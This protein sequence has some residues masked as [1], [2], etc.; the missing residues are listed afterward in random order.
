S[1]SQ[2]E[3]WSR[4]EYNEAGVAEFMAEWKAA[5]E[6]TA[7]ENHS[8]VVLRLSKSWEPL[9]DS[10]LSQRIIIIGQPGSGK[11]NSVADIIEEIGPLGVPL[12]LLDTEG[13]YD[14][15][16]HS[17]YLPHGETLGAETIMPENAREFGRSIPAE[18]LQVIL[19][20]QSYKADDEAALVICELIAGINEWE[21]AQPAGGRV[22]CMVILDEAAVWLPQAVNESILSKPVLNQLQQT[23]FSTVVRRGRKR[24][25]GFLLATQRVAEIDKRALSATWVVLHRQTLP[26]DLKVYQQYGIEPEEARAL[27]PGQAYVLGPGD[28][29]EIVQFRKRYSQDKAFTPGLASVRSHTPQRSVTSSRPAYSEQQKAR[30]RA[31]E[32][33]LRGL[34]QTSAPASQERAQQGCGADE[35]KARQIAPSDLAKAFALWQAGADSVRK[36]EAAGKEVGYGWSN[37]MCRDLISAMREHGLIPKREPV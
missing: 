14:G 25:I 4:E 28:F 20:L 10:F 22:S 5:Q 19:N 31:R 3:E 7:Q 21:E 35:P 33:R 27:R 13:E 11:S 2:E 15:L 24:G 32:L 23:F 29:H 36:L 17:R 1:D 37:G 6:R 34:A 12:L 8:V 18:K 16:C 9:A 26:N 30:T